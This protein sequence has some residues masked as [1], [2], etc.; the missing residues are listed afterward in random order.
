MGHC[1]EVLVSQIAPLPLLNPTF[2]IAHRNFA[3]N[4]DSFGD[5]IPGIESGD[6]RFLPSFGRQT[7][8]ETHLRPGKASH[9]QK[10][11]L[12]P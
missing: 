8:R 11:N 7:N 4:S 3:P 5:E 1:P 12:V 10:Q 9:S 2:F 6:G